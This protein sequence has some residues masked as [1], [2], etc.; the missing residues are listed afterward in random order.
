MARLRHVFSRHATLRAK[1]SEGL[2]QCFEFM[3][4]QGWGAV[5]HAPNGWP[6]FMKKDWADLSATAKKALEKA[7][8]PVFGF[9][10]FPPV[11]TVQRP[12]G[13]AGES[14]DNTRE[15]ICRPGFVEC[16]GHCYSSA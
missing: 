12:R 8:I 5:Q 2:L 7:D 6:V 3:Q 4:G 15:E 10:S 16:D 1:A 11:P 9:V 14:A 13:C